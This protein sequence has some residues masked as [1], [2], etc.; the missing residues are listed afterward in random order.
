[1]NIFSIEGGLDDRMQRQIIDYA[2][3]LSDAD[4]NEA[5]AEAQ[6]MFNAFLEMKKSSKNQDN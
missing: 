2:A 1:M 5:Q 6:S 4:I 3:K